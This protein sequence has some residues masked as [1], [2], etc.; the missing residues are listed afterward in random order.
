MLRVGDIVT[1]TVGLPHGA[2]PEA[3]SST[4]YLDTLVDYLQN[5]NSLTQVNQ[6]CV[7]TSLTLETE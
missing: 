7:H 3:S 4:S 2:N 5:S 6:T 1:T